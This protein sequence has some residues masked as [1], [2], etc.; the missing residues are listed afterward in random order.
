MDTID[1]KKF[2]LIKN[3][4]HDVGSWAIW[5]DE[6]EKPISNIGDLSVLDPDIN[7]SLLSKLNPNIIFVGF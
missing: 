5:A 4:Y 7:R 1:R 6:G 2:D 3:K